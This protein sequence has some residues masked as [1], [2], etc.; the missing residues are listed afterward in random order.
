MKKVI[1]FYKHLLA[2]FFL[3]E[4]MALQ[5]QQSLSQ[6]TANLPLTKSN[7]DSLVE[8]YV[9]R[10]IYFDFGSKELPTTEVEN[11]EEILHLLKN[12]PPLKLEIIGHTDNKE[13]QSLSISRAYTIYQWFINHGIEKQ[14]VTYK[15]MG[16]VSP[17]VSNS[18][19]EYRQLN[20]RVEFNITK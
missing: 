6:D 11:L 10:N 18:N 1:P 2:L 15:S 8:I 14:Y 17:I 19:P 4:M 16:S 7:N 20:R 13:T 12:H 5:A 9:L 3:C